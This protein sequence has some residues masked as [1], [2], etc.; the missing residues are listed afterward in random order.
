M[1]QL[2]AA[3]HDGSDTVEQMTGPGQNLWRVKLEVSLAE[4]DAEHPQLLQGVRPQ[5]RKRPPLLR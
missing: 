1:L 2:M 4:G 5:R 3:T